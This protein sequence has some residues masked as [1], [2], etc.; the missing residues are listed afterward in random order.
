MGNP[1]W[2]ECTRSNPCPV[3]GRTSW[4]TRT[5]DGGAVICKDVP[6]ERASGQGWVHHLNRVPRERTEEQAPDVWPQVL[7]AAARITAGKRRAI[8]RELQLPSG[9]TELMSYVGIGR[10]ATGEH[11]LFPMWD[12]SGDLV[13]Y[14]RRYRD[15]KLS[16]GRNGLFLPLKDPG[17]EVVLIVEGASDVL[18]AAAMGIYAIGRPSNTGGAEQLA[19]F[20]RHERRTIVVVGEND[21]KPDGSIPGWSGMMLVRDQLGP[22]LRPAR[23]LA[24][25]MPAGVKDLRAW[26]IQNNYDRDRCRSLFG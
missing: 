13:G 25:P 19:G 15:K 26:A 23:V 1:A 6:S 5:R 8:E 11:V 9:T 22:R 10:D 17:G 24:R 16:W 4:C 7:E 21:E 14:S 3:C 20:L 12:G 18:A 2:K